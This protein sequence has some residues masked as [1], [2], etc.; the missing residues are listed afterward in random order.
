M[1][2]PT[3]IDPVELKKSVETLAKQEGLTEIETIS[4]LQ[5]GA[6]LIGNSTLLGALCE[7]KWDYI[8]EV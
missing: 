7:L 2:E 5:T 8:E 4:L 1:T 3:S 6:A